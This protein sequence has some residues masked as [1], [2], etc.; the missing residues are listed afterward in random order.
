MNY[1]YEYHIQGVEVFPN[2]NGYQNVVCRIIYTITGRYEQ[3]ASALSD[4]DYIDYEVGTEFIQFENLTKETLVNWLETNVP[5]K[6][7]N[8]KKTIKRELDRQVFS[9]YLYVT[10]PFGN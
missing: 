7:E 10:P 2:Y 8:I 3:Y 9:D 5:Q 1:T 4:S 6:I